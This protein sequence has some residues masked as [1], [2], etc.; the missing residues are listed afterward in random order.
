M[1][2]DTMRGEERAPI[3]AVRT[4]PHPTGCQADDLCA[5]RP[6]QGCGWVAR[7]ESRS[8]AQACHAAN[9]FE[10]SRQSRSGIRRSR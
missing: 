7:M 2:I 9:C 3:D 5:Q 10:R 6:H 1:S 4:S 8:I